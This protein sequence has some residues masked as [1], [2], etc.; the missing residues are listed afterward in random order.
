MLLDKQKQEQ[1]QN[2][3]QN[4]SDCILDLL[5]PAVIDAL[6]KN[7][8]VLTFSSDY[9]FMQSPILMRRLNEYNCVERLYL[10]GK[11]DSRFAPFDASL[12]VK[13]RNEFIGVF[14]TVDQ[15]ILE[16][17]SL[18]IVDF[19]T[20]YSDDNNYNFSSDFLKY[21]IN[22]LCNSKSLTSII[23][24]GA[25]ITCKDV[26]SIVLNLGARSKVNF[27]NIVYCFEKSDDQPCYES[28]TRLAS[29][30]DI[31]IGYNR[32]IYRD[33]DTR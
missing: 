18:I 4:M 31:L 19:S 14:H 27:I 5:T 28:L 33:Q 21:F 7:S 24:R 32:S 8:R 15:F 30:L 1:G 12:G 22:G 17:K 25:D 2:Q 3:E 13:L 9:V 23:L 16:S 11:Y 20:S 10:G 6:K 26:L 29:R